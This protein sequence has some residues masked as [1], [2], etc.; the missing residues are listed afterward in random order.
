MLISK[1]I[2]KMKMQISKEIN[3][4]NNTAGKTNWQL[5]FDDRIIRNRTG[6]FSV[7]NYIIENPKKIE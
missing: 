5:D 3:Q 2:G 1:I 4:F 7:K 6:F